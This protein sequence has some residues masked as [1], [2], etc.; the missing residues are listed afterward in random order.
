MVDD[1]EWAW[2]EEHAQGDFDHLLIAS[3]LPWL[4]G[5]GMHYVEAWSE[6]VVGGAWGKTWARLGE[7]ARRTV[8]LEHWAAFQ[9]S[10]AKLRELQ[11]SVGAGER[12]RPPASIVTLS[13]RR[14]S[15]LSVRGRLQARGR[16][17]ERD[18]AGRLLA[19]PQSARR[20]GAPR[21]P[22]RD[23]APSGAV[24]KAL[25][26][27]AGVEDAGIRWR[28]T[29]GGPWFDNQVATLQIDGREMRMRLDKAVPVDEHEARLD[30]V[31]DRRLA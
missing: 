11:R 27:R 12:G 14:P 28:L 15:R 10:F 4:L 30:R 7:K 21:H 2:I 29:D 26:R 19:L 16:C 25:A 23:V 31:L 17:E 8:D 18:L 3:S 22:G 9:R 20:Q 5:P 13:G 1:E 24:A 6:A